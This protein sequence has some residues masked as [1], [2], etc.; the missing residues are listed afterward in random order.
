MKHTERVVD[1]ID[2]AAFEVFSV[3]LVTPTGTS[4]P[5]ST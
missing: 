1:Q 5:G 2:D 4:S 3:V